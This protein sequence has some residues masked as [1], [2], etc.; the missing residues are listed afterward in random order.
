M[1]M[2][3]ADPNQVL[4]RALGGQNS[5]NNFTASRLAPML[6]GL[7]AN[8]PAPVP[9]QAEG[10]QINFAALSKVSDP[11]MQK[12]VLQWLMGL[13][14]QREEMRTKQQGGLQ[15]GSMPFR[16]TQIPPEQWQDAA[17][18]EAGILPRAGSETGGDRDLNELAKWQMITKNATESVTDK[19]TGKTETRTRPGQQRII[20]LAERNIATIEKRMMAEAA[21]ELGVSAST[22]TSAPS[23]SVEQIM[24]HSEG[25]NSLVRVFPTLPAPVQQ[26]I[27]AALR[28]GATMDEILAAPDLESYMFTNTLVQRG[29]E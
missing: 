3:N 18:R 29:T 27:Q 20:G 14:M 16:Y 21:K 1:V 7:V 28:A 10:P 2:A 11:D 4:Q 13:A 22:L 25:V 15:I 24:S 17:R 12:M 9:Q 23:N 8:A 5:A 6:A 19:Y 26:K